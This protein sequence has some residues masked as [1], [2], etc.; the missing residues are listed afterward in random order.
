VVEQP[1]DYAAVNNAMRYGYQIFVGPMCWNES[2]D[3]PQMKGLGRYIAEAVRIREE[4]IDTIYNGE[5]ID[6]QHVAVSD[7]SNKLH[8]NTHRNPSTGKRACVLSNSDATAHDVTVY[9]EN[10]ESGELFVYATFAEKITV[11]NP[12]SASV[13]PQRFIVVVEA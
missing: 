13:P 8:Y 2:M 4:L 9:F 11:Q 5:Y 1:F 12:V 3:C 6:K 10:N 7:E